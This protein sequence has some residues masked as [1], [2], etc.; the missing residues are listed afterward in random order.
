MEYFKQVTVVSA[1]N[2]FSAAVSA[3]ES[4]PRLKKVVIM[5]QI[6]RYDTTQVDPLGIKASLSTLYNNTLTDLWMESNFRDRIFVGNHN[7]DCTGAI[8]Q[9][10]YMDTQS[11]R[12]DGIHLYGSSGMKFYTLSVLNILKLANITSEEYNY[13][14]SC[15]Q[16]QYMKKM[17][18]T[19]DRSMN[20]NFNQRISVPVHNRF[21]VLQGN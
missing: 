15:P 16:S 21:S 13:H 7:I 12:Y 14:L 18:N 11:G 3:L 4:E 6:P 9:A 10:R 19:S 8:R 20:Y 2:L 5:K 17:K 1:S